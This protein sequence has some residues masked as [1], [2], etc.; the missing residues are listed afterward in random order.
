[1]LKSLFF[2]LLFAVFACTQNPAYVVIHPTTSPARNGLPLNN[3][4]KVIVQKGETLY[5]ISHKNN[6]EIR[7]VIEI[8]SLR[9]PYTLIIGQSLKLPKA[10]F[11]IVS[12]SDN[13]YAISRSYGV[14]ISRLAKKNNLSEP[15]NLTSGQKLMLPSPA[16]K[17]ANSNITPKQG[18]YSGVPG[19]DNVAS[20]KII[21]SELTPFHKEPAR[22][23]DKK[24]GDTPFLLQKNNVSQLVKSNKAN[25][26][27]DKDDESFKYKSEQ[28][29]AANEADRENV[30]PSATSQSINQ[31]KTLLKKTE[32]KSDENFPSAALKPE[33]TQSQPAQKESARQEFVAQEEDTA[34][35]DQNHFADGLAP[36]DQSAR[37]SDNAVKPS[38]YWPVKGSVIS[39]F[40]PKKGG[41]YNDGINISAKAGAPIKA[42][43]GGEVVY[44]GNELRGY[45]NMLLIKH[46][47]GYLTAYAHMDD[48]L[49]KKGDIITKGQ[50]IAHVGQTGHVTSP[51]LH[52]SIRQGR[53]AIDP[54]KYLSSS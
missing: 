4:Y 46:N 28:E 13:L 41:L 54:E 30:T 33:N 32:N 1:V 34:G 19:V 3:P 35:A 40:G 27:P 18:K 23:S 29:F 22:K 11:H 44:A 47:N 31:E 2:A 16:E 26:I 53:K 6:V 20:S 48:F 8:N 5:S 12:G 24:D 43:D 42:A 38:F 51:Q 25:K 21:S 9:P 7:D 52:F 37:M 50:V 39:K 17:D 10:T 49:V 15:Y 14:D 36:E 45:G